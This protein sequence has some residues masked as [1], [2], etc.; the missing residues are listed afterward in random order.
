[1]SRHRTLGGAARRG[2][3]Q[4]PIVALT[5]VLLVGLVWFG[6]SYTGDLLER[7][8]AA[9]LASCMKGEETLTI[10][11]TPSMASVIEQA[12]LAWGKT[13]PVVL[14]HCM[15]AEVARVPSQDVL[16]GLTVSWDTKSLG[17]RPG[18]WLPESSL[19]INRLIAQNPKLLGSEPASIAT[20]PVV[21]AMPEQAAAAIP[22]DSVFRW[23]DL[24]H[25]VGEADAWKRFGH[26]DWGGFT[27]AMPDVASNSASALALQSML[28][29]AGPQGTGPVTLDVLNT[30][31]AGEVM[32][33]LAAAEPPSVPATTL[34]ALNTLA[35]ADVKA[36][37]FDA[38]PI[39]E[40]D[41]YRRNVGA[42][43]SPAPALTGVMVNGP[44]PT[45]DF[46]FIALVDERVDQL[47]V[48][49]AQKFR[50]FL[51]TVPQQAALAQAGLRV[52]NSTARP[53]PA[54]GIQWMSTPENLTAADADT[55]QQISAAWT[56]AGGGR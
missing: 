35:T 11:V 45:A 23:S 34:D 38:V 6:W 39:L 50:E 1:M 41:L 32:R 31:A 18:A 54:P 12:A 48:R 5:S 56:N 25:L 20:S 14:D 22:A 44:T 40:Y 24:P 42:D 27:V 2:V 19:W 10:A 49:A 28:A 33:K 51:L 52:P 8:A 55:T 26:P 53:D 21:L 36:A 7:R 46:P 17:T 15:R 47:H 37:P 30:P 16:N 43:G 9:E 4:W 13:H 3:A 29:G